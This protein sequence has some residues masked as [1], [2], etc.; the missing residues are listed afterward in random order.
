MK[1]IIALLLITFGFLGCEKDDICDAATVTTPKLVIHFY[2]STTNL[3]KNV[4]NLKVIA[5]GMSEGVVFNSS[6]T[7]DEK[8]LANAVSSIKIPLKTTADAT[9]YT[10]IYNFGSSNASTVFTDILTFNYTRK[11]EYISRACGYKTIF[12]LNNSAGLPK[13][14]ILNNLETN[15]TGNWI[16][17][18][19]IKKYNITSENETHI[20]IYF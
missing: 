17:G 9:K 7:T 14:V 16:D 5:D 4:V 18:I 11:N 3:S 10:L 20:D 13:A 19:T 2:D 15:T 1:K 6:L 8:Y 12:D